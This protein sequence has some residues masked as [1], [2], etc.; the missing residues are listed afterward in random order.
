MGEVVTVALEEITRLAKAAG[1]PWFGSGEAADRILEN[2]CIQLERRTIGEE[3]L[4]I[5]CAEA[6]EE[7]D[8]ALE[9]SALNLDMASKAMTERD[10]L[11]RQLKIL[12]AEGLKKLEI[13][14]INLVKADFD[15][16][17]LANKDG[18]ALVI[19]REPKT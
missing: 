5:A 18:R 13:E 1:V 12:T 17:V 6:R 7:R 19:I 3:Q 10:S 16:E 15:V 2:V 11:D 8:A 4:M 9:L 14:V